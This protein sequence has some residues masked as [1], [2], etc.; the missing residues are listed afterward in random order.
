[1]FKLDKTKPET[2][3]EFLKFKTLSYN[4]KSTF[5]YETTAKGKIVFTADADKDLQYVFLVDEKFPDDIMVKY[6][7]KKNKK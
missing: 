6:I 4:V 2:Y 1:H 5:K 3:Y 7:L